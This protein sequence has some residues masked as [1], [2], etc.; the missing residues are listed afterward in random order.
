MPLVRIDVIEG[1]NDQ[2]LTLLA[3]TI[4]DV[5]IQTFFIPQLYMTETL[6][7][8]VTFDR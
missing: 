7:G 2:Q 5:L 3:D 1:R 6:S 8:F 4:Q